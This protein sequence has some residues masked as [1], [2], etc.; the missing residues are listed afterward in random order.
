V[1]IALIGEHNRKGGGSYHQSIKTY[2]LLSGLKDFQ[3]SLLTIGPNNKTNKT[4]KNYIYYNPNIIDQ[5]FFLFYSSNI[6]KS[7]LKKFKIQ[8]KFEKFIKKNKIDIIIY[9]GVSRFSIFCD[10]ID[11]ITYIYEFHHL[12]CP[13]LPEYKSWSDFDF[14]ENLTKISVKKSISLIVDTQKKSNDLIKYYNCYDKK[15]NIIPLTPNFSNTNISKIDNSKTEEKFINNPKEYFFYPAQY[16]PHK[17][18][19]YILSAIKTLNTKYKKNVNFIFTGQ[20]KNNFEYLNKKVIEFGLQDQV[21]FFEYLMDDEIKFLYNNCKALVVPSLVGYS[22][23]TLYEAFYYKKPVFYTKDLLDDTLKEFVNEIDIEN[24][25]SLADEINNF[26]QNKEKIT[27]KIVKANKYFIE[28]LSDEK[29]KFCYNN[30]LNKIQNQ[31]KIY[32]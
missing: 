18:H 12:F 7:F 15:I 14:R 11:Y 16:W 13:N 28:N 17:N 2:E 27:K 6:F 4:D 24:S 20:K 31:I 23:L 3:F 5:L 30:L 26:D 21:T 10:K 19:Y 25:E 29:I 32:K 9:L 22:S 1:K 8:N